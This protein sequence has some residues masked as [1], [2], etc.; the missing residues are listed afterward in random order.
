VETVKSSSRNDTDIKPPVKR[1]A[2]TTVPDIPSASKNRDQREKAADVRRRL[3]AGTDRKTSPLADNVLRGKTPPVITNESASLTPKSDLRHPVSSTGKSGGA[4]ERVKKIADRNRELQHSKFYDDWKSGGLDRIAAGETAKKY[5]IAEQYRMMQQGDVA[6]RLALASVAASPKHPPARGPHDYDR[7]RNRYDDDNK[8][9]SRPGFHHGAIHGTYRDHC[10]EYNY[11]GPRFF[12]G[13]CWYPK[14]QPWVDWSWRYHCTPYWDP[15]PVWCRPVV[16]AACPDWVYWDTPTFAPLPSAPCG[17][18]VD[19]KPVVVEPEATDLQLVA[20]RFVDPGHPEERTGPRY[21]VWFRNNSD[22]A[23]TTPFNVMLFAANGDRLTADLP[24]A[25]A[26]VTSIE[27]G[28]TQSVDVRLPVEVLTM[29]QDARGNPA[30][31]SVLHVLVDANLEVQDGTRNNNGIRLSPTEILPV[32]P[33]AFELEPKIVRVNDKVNLAGEGF[34][35]EPGQ[36][37]LRVAGQ[38]VQAEIL[39]WYDLGV[40]WQ[41]PRLLIVA[42]IEASVIV[43]RGDGAAANPLKITLA[44]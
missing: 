28:D 21:R 43:I 4:S 32:D 31:F 6:R 42:P 1:Q 40:R 25:G 22:H 37:L 30:P 15:R 12:A 2:Q 11:W 19:L 10:I 35:P 17:T 36:V 16:Y 41:L 29:S 34:G 9:R 44:P 38:E 33:A 13:P 5:H 23:V 18:W 24:Q 3:D 20:V 39:G 27:A 14:W 7:F 8:Y 26:R